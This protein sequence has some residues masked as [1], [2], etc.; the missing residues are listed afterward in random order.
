MMSL[1][2]VPPI[3]PPP[4]LARPETSAAASDAASANAAAK[5]TEARN[6]VASLNLT[7]PLPAMAHALTGMST[8]EVA[9]AMGSLP[10]VMG[11]LREIVMASSNPALSEADRST[12]QA[13]YSALTHQVASVVGSTTASADS[14]GTAHKGR[15]SAASDS[16]DR[17]PGGNHAGGS[18]QRPSTP[19]SPAVP[20]GRA[21]SSAVDSSS[22]GAE[23]AAA[24]APLP[25]TKP[26]SVHAAS[27]V[28]QFVPAAPSPVGRVSL[29]A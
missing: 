10:A 4:A 18:K 1:N 9:G 24:P 23:V 8:V 28:A 29:L 15:D 27:A 13:E 22:R 7:G 12:L 21:A 5:S 26:V 6:A 19:G 20:V 2:A 16:K 25:A 17:E 3:A 11:R 14:T